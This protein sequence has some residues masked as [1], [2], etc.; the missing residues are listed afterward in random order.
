[1]ERLCHDMECIARS[2]SD[3]AM[4]R[5]ASNGAVLPCTA[6]GVNNLSET[7]HAA[8]SDATKSVVHATKTEATETHEHVQFF[9]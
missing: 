6:D 9:L 8:A 4:T 5:I 2:W 7:G 1:M 3:P